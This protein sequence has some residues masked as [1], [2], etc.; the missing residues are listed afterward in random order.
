MEILESLL[1]LQMLCFQGLLQLQD[2]IFFVVGRL[3]V[4]VNVVYGHFVKVPRSGIGPGAEAERSGGVPNKKNSKIN[5]AKQIKKIFCIE[6]LGFEPNFMK[7]FCN[8]E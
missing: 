7:R 4:R 5:L 1:G 2:P 6:I 3:V 8:M